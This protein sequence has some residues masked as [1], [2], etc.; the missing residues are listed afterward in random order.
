MYLIL[1]QTNS[2]ADAFYTVRNVYAEFKAKTANANSLC[3]LLFAY[4]V[5][6]APAVT[7]VYVNLRRKKHNRCRFNPAYIMSA[8]Q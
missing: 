8:T 2:H 6:T 3:A 5:Q 1:Q 4:G 7:Y